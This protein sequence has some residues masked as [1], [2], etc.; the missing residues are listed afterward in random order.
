MNQVFFFFFFFNSDGTTSLLKGIGSD[1]V[2]KIHGGYMELIMMLILTPKELL[3]Q[4]FFMIT[5]PHMCSCRR[6]RRTTRVLHSEN[7]F[8]CK[9]VTAL[10][11][12]HRISL[13]THTHTK[14][15]LTH[16]IKY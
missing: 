8:V 16:C 1:K 14:P 9:Y 6:R 12:S 15:D 5:P 3:Q 2:G 4:C 13:K 11:Q 10:F 7:I